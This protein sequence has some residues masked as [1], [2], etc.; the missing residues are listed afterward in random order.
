MKIYIIQLFATFLVS[1]ISFAQENFQ[2]K[3]YLNE[4]I[5]IEKI[6]IYIDNGKTEYSAPKE[7]IGNAIYINGPYFGEY[8]QITI[9]YPREVS[10]NFLVQ[11]TF[12]VKEK[13]AEIKLNRADSVAAILNNYSFT[14]A[15]DFKAEKE[16]MSTYD[17]EAIKA[18]EDFIQKYGSEVFNDTTLTKEF[19]KLEKVIYDRDMEYIL[20]NMDS[21]YAFSFFRRNFVKPGRIT[22]DS[23][24]TVLNSFPER[25]KNS[26]EAN[27]M[28]ELI[29]GRL[30]VKKDGQAP[31]FQTKD[32]SGKTISLKDYQ[33]KELFF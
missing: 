14:N 16:K 28:R 22:S 2:A 33:N 1:S 7:V 25:F 9:R 11:S 23:M 12:F 6:E 18:T 21:Y 10:S 29:H 24:L 30:V 26:H 13:L 20:D 8:A 31:D 32:I 15:T 4:D 19:F 3:I 27:F 17:S 5:D